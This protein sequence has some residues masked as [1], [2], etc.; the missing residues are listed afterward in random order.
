MTLCGGVPV[1]FNAPPPET[2]I[3]ELLV[4]TTGTEVVGVGGNYSGLSSDVYSQNFESQRES[5]SPNNRIRG[6]AG[7]DQTRNFFSSAY[8]P[9]DAFNTQSVTI[10]RGANAI[11]FGFGSPAGIIDYTLVAPQF[12]NRGQIQVRTGSFGGYRESIDIDRVVIKDKPALRIAAVD[13]RKKFEQEP[14]FRDQR[15]LFGSI[16]IK[17][18]RATTIRLN[19]E[20]GKIAQRLP[21]VDPPL[22]SLTTWWWFGKPTRTNLF[23]A[24]VSAYQRANNLDGQAGGWAQN[25]A[26][27]YA[28]VNTHQPTDGLVAYATAPNGVVYRHLGPRSTKEVAQFHGLGGDF[29]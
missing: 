23:P 3:A 15:R 25:P 1:R 5:A 28:D 21:R 7:A 13:E 8:I 11:L 6:L 16:T 12:K 19:A 4:Y 22:D 29:L 14:A 9:M 2:G 24:T 18:F 27:I 20:T 17:P 10:N 26:L